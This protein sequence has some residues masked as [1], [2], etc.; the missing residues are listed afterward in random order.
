MTKSSTWTALKN[1]AFRKLW[2]ATVISGLRGRPRYRGH[3]VNEPAHRVATFD[4][5]DVNGGIASFFSVHIARRRP[6]R[7]SGPSEVSMC[8]QSLVGRHGSRFGGSWLVPSA[9]SLPHP[10]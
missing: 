4:I 1:P 2:F 10:G 3:L 9:Q 7:Q 5:A 6:R 8:H